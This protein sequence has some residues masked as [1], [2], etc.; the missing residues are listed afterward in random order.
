MEV[1]TLIPTHNSEATIMRALDSCLHQ[2]DRV[3]VYDDGSQD[4]TLDLVYSIADPKLSIIIPIICPA[5][6]CSKFTSLPA[7]LPQEVVYFS[8]GS[9]SGKHGIQELRIEH[10][11]TMAP[12]VDKMSSTDTGFSILSLFDYTAFKSIRAIMQKRTCCK[13]LIFFQ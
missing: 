9:R 10:F 5:H 4:T 2:S 1:T 11:L 7:C 6:F 8:L 13:W 12:E 3:I